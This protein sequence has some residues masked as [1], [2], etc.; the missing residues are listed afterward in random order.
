[1]GAEVQEEG[2]TYEAP[3][4]LRV[5]GQRLGAGD[6]DR[7]GSGDLGACVYPGNSA[8]E[9]C[10]TAGSGAA[11]CKTPGSSAD[12]CSTGNTPISTPGTAGCVTGGVPANF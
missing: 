11:G 4:A 10:G 3:R 8:G 6:C 5:G 12:A 7:V 2:R 1:M 9:A